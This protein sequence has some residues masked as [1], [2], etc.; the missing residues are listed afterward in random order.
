MQK[1]ILFIPKFVNIYKQ[2]NLFFSSEY[3]CY[4]QGCVI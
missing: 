4:N 2:A 1:K 3:D